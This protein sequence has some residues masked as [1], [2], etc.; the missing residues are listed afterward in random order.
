M[1]PLGFA[2]LAKVLKAA[3]KGCT[4]TKMRDMDASWDCAG[5]YACCAQKPVALHGIVRAGTLGHDR[6]RRHKTKSSYVAIY[7]HEG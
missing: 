2:F 3:F 4:P 1:G 7:T 6:G 5:L